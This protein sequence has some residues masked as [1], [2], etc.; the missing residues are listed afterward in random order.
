MKENETVIVI[1][2]DLRKPMAFDGNQF[3]FV[4]PIFKRR[5]RASSFV[6]QVYSVEIAKE[7]I[8]KSKRYRKK[9]GYTDT[10]YLL[11]K[12]QREIIEY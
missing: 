12:T 4:E 10:E 3:C 1:D 11:I 9:K 5:G 7:L 2:G 6:L 8:A